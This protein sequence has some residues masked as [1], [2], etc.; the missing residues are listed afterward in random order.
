ML[1]VTSN[2]AEVI[3]SLVSDMPNAGL[4]ISSRARVDDPERVEVGLSVTDTP[5]PTDEVVESNGCQVFV[6]DQVAPLVADKTLDV[7]EAAGGQHV[8]FK[9]VS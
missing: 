1:G 3:Q 7:E 6:E 5:A 8:A 9:F 4:R 2:A